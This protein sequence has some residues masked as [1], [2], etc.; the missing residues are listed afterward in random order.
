VIK[1]VAED[2]PAA[3]VGLR[4]GDVVLDYN[5]ERVEGM[6]Q[7]V[8]LVRETPPGRQVRLSVWR[9]GAIQKVDVTVASRSEK[10]WG[11]ADGGKEFSFTM[12]PIPPLPP[13]PPVTFT[14]PDLPRNLMAW[15]SSAL[16][17]ES[18]SLTTQLAEFF[19]VKE[20]VLVRSVTPNSPAGKAGIK[21]GDVIVKIG[22]T[23]VTNPR[24]IFSALRS[25]NTKT[26]PL[27]IVRN[28]KDMTVT[29]TVD[30]SQGYR[31]VRPVQG[32]SRSIGNGAPIRDC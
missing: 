11:S 6:E 29:V 5:N 28:R 15:R 20:G 31:G 22:D 26:F 17:L 27:V 9:N 16:G 8:R 32:Q 30:E 24:E 2:S 21:A 23:Y 3:K 10:W 7:L 14:M 1:S 12:P 18:E 25:V 4:E 13:M 19:A